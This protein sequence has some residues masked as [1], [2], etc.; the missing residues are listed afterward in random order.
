[1]SEK[2]KMCGKVMPE[3]PVHPWLRRFGWLI[4]PECWERWKLVMWNDL[5]A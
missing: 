3:H 4:C 1:M 2:C 5:A